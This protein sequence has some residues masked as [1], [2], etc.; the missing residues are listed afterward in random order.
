MTHGKCLFKCLTIPLLGIF[1]LLLSSA[2]IFSKLTLFKKKSYRMSNGLDPDQDQLSVS[3][4]LGPGY[5]QTV[6]VATGKEMVVVKLSL[7]H[8]YPWSGVVLDCVDS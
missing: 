7:S 6:N 2:C 1:L 4:G 5:W 8:L 3:P